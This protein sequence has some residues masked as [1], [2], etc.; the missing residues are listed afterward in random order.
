MS[1]GRWEQLFHELSKAE[2]ATCRHA[3]F[4]ACHH[5]ATLLA[6]TFCI[7]GCESCVVCDDG[8]YQV[9][10]RRIVAHLKDCHGRYAS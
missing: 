6:G 10:R 7:D 2:P 3:C 1:N 9:D 5:P 8:H 4:C